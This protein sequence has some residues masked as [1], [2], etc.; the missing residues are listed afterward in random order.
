MI[1][2]LPL[3][4]PSVCA[5]L[6]QSGQH[7]AVCEPYRHQCRMWLMR[8]R[9]EVSRSARPAYSRRDNTPYIRTART[10]Q[11]VVR[12]AGRVKRV[13]VFSTRVWEREAFKADRADLDALAS[14]GWHGEAGGGGVRAGRVDRPA[15]SAGASR[16]DWTL[17][18]SE[19]P[20]QGY[21]DT[22][23][24]RIAG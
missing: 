18:P 5:Y 14:R 2:R 22:L 1:A 23:Y 11:P 4:A 3:P 13:A 21:L 20:L 16:P 7:S 10:C 17:L 8:H 6:R 19:L 9:E 12:R 15:A 24:G